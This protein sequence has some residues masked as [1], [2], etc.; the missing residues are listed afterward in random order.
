MVCLGTLLL[1]TALGVLLSFALLAAMVASDYWYFL[2]VAATGNSMGLGPLSSHLGLW[3]ICEGHNGCIPLIDPFAIKSLE[4]TSVQHDL[5]SIYLLPQRSLGKE[6]AGKAFFPMDLRKPGPGL[7]ATGSVGGYHGDGHLREADGSAP[8]AVKEALP[9]LPLSLILIVC[10]W[11]Y[12]LLS[13]LVIPLLLFTNCHFFLGGALTLAVVSIYISYLYLAFTETVQ[14]YNPRPVQDADICFGYSC[15][16]EVLSGVLLLATARALSLNWRPGAP[17]SV[18]TFQGPNCRICSSLVN[19]CSFQ[20]LGGYPSWASVEMGFWLSMSGVEPE[21]L[22]FYQAFRP[23]LSP[24]PRTALWGSPPRAGLTADSGV[25]AIVVI[26]YDRL[27]F[28]VTLGRSGLGHCVATQVH[29][30]RPDP[31]PDS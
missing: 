27:D 6:G 10:G 4:S 8:P 3:H 16:S 24:A 12:G 7:V 5:W 15:A 17:H 29:H 21:N 23:P 31:P 9:T 18:L 28:G 11:I 2:E 26:P 19:I 20:G 14:R 13:S 22:N 25:L 30:V 1:A